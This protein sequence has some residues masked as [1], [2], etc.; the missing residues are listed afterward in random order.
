MRSRLFAALVGLLLATACRTSAVPSAT[1]VGPGGDGP[2]ILAVV[3]HPDDEIAFA[4]VLY[5]TATHLGGTCDV[6]VLTNG[7]GGFKYATLSER[8]YGLE[9]TEEAVGRAH[10]PRIRAREL[11]AGCRILGV[12]HVYY[13][14]QRDHR[15]TTDLDEV[16]GAEAHVWDLEAV[17]E[18]LREL[19]QAGR[20]DLVLTLAPVPSTHAHHQAATHLARAAVRSLAPGERPLVLCSKP[21]SGEVVPETT[22]VELV[23]DRTQKFGHRE[24]LDYRIVANWAI[25][26]HKSQGTM[27]LLVNQGERETYA[28]FRDQEPEALER[29]R[30]LFERLAE[31]QF[32]PRVYTSSAGTNA[33]SR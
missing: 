10:L 2:R 25:A 15:Y 29:A 1:V 4:G 26:E 23:F 14:G 12:R 18:G 6:A 32:E 8:L 27:Q 21:S 31:P 24:R 5:K 33:T 30:R 11:E 20:Y 16:L 19:L 7:E 3:A 13:F 28:P 22:D 9:L 17:S